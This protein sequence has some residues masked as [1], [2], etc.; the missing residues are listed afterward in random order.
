MSQAVR[1]PK[2]LDIARREGGVSVERLS[3]HFG[4]TLQTIRRDLAELAEAGQLERVHGGAVLPSGTVNIAYEERRRLHAGGKAAIARACAAQI[5]DGASVF[6][7]I[8]TTAEAVAAA[9]VHHRG[10]L[11]VTNN[12]NAA[13]ILGPRDGEVVVT[14]GTMRAADGGLVGDLARTAVEGF[15]FDVAV[16]GCSALDPSGDVLDFDGREAGVSRAAVARSRRAFLAADASKFARTAPVRVLSLEGLH[17]FVTDAPPPAALRARC[18]GWGTRVE[19]C[20]P[21]GS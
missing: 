7:A 9:L 10:L 8:G 21:G 1:H 13:R 17:A 6:L 15:R 3:E 2:I 20:P 12:V 19:V 5:P 4:V 14:G 11:V 16:V 18:E